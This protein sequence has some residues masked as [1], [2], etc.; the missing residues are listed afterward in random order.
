MRRS[1]NEVATI[2]TREKAVVVV[3]EV[4]DDQSRVDSVIDKTGKGI[5]SD[6]AEEAQSKYM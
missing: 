5:L 6:E 3:D 4:E 1:Q 2:D